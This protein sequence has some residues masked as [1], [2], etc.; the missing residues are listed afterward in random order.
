MVDS[1][2]AE[3]GP[4]G[5]RTGIAVLGGSFNPPHA[6]HLRLVQTALDRL[7]V[8]EVR[9]VP[10]AEH[11]HKQH[12][13]MAPAEHRLAMCRLA[14]A[15]EPRAIV[16]DREL[17]RAGPS[18]TV[19]TLREIAAEHPGRTVW[20]L[21]GSDNLRLLPTWRDHHGILELAPVVTYPRA[22]HPVRAEDLAALD[23]TPTEQRSLLAHVLDAPPDAVNA[24]ELRRRW[25]RGEHELAEIPP[26]VRRYIE[27]NRVY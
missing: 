8:A 12:R 26:L 16:D 25:R 6:T 15:G 4:R 7:P 17:R 27:D 18:F 22:G 13:D 11:P 10:A 9:I 1:A 24:T 20:F 14:F 23:L 2:E 5:P 3:A 21:I 19:D